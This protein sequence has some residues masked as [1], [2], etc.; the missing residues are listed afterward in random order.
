[1]KLHEIGSRA[2]C[3]HVLYKFNEHKKFVRYSQIQAIISIQNPDS[4]FFDIWVYLVTSSLTIQY[5]KV[6]TIS[7]A[8]PK[9]INR[10]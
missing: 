2:K 1:M 7:T 4:V 5:T 10:V 3:M 6:F 9:N 8:N